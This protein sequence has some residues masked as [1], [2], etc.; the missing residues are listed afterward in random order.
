MIDPLPSMIGLSAVIG[1]PWAKA[2][3]HMYTAMSADSIYFIVIL[4]F[5]YVI[6]GNHLTVPSEHFYGISYYH[7][8]T[9]KNTSRYADQCRL[10]QVGGDREG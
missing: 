7:S 1:G 6:I 8:N 4:A 10:V 5:V 2:Q 9:K 3:L